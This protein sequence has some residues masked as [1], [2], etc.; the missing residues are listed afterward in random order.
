MKHGIDT[1]QVGELRTIRAPDRVAAEKIA[2]YFRKVG[3]E[4]SKG[5]TYFVTRKCKQG[6]KV[7]RVA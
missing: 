1:F 7:R 3:N 5:K 6:L 4:L 2:N